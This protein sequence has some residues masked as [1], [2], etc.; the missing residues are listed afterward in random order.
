[1]TGEPDFV[2]AKQKISDAKNWRGDVNV[3]LGGETVTFKHR[4]LTENEFIDLRRVFDMS[5]VDAEKQNV[6]ETEAQQRLLE[7]QQKEEELTDEEEEELRE[8]TNKVAAQTEDIEKAL[9]EDAYDKIMEMGQKA[10]RVSDE[11]VEYVYDQGPEEMRRLMG[12]DTL[13][14]PITKKTV[15][16]HLES[17]LMD[18]VEDQPFPIKMNVGMQ[19]FSETVSVLGNGFQQ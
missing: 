3:S 8:L 18:M 19:A 10:I 14:N 9:G 2:R 5:E 4:L 1:M 15:R 6:G 11:D 13:P 7:L 17:E 16:E 12:V